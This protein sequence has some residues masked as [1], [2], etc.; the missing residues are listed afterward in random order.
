MGPGDA[1]RRG[2]PSR[3]GP[4]GGCERRIERAIDVPAATPRHG[5]RCRDDG[6]GGRVHRSYRSARRFARQGEIGPTPVVPIAGQR[7]GC[8]GPQ[9]AGSGSATE[10]ARTGADRTRSSCD[11]SRPKAETR[12]G[13]TALTAQPAT[14]GRRIRPHAPSDGAATTAREP[15]TLRPFTGRKDVRR[16]MPRR[17]ERR[18]RESRR[19]ARRPCPHGFVGKPAATGRSAGVLRNRLARLVNDRRPVARLDDGSPAGPERLAV[20]RP[21]RRSA[22]PA[23]LRLRDGSPPARRR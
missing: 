5:R 6:L 1:A 22:A 10:R 23:V 3:R 2:L 15:P 7:A 12:R 21:A 16:R 8:H 19:D 9:I 11:S 13:A 20:G 17:C 4:D 14:A 18:R